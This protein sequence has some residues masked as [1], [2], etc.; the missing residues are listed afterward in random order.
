MSWPSGQGWLSF[1][2]QFEPEI[3]AVW[4]ECRSE[5]LMVEYINKWVFFYQMG[6]QQTRDKQ[7]SI[8]IRTN[9]TIKQAYHRANNTQNKQT[10][11]LQH[12][13]RVI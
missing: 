4:P 10:V 7:L 9:C 3:K 13:E 8:S 12:P 11:A 1:D 5:L 6:K 2:C